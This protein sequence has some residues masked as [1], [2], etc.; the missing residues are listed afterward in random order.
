MLVGSIQRV[1]SRVVVGGASA[2]TLSLQAMAIRP[3]SL[4]A[5]A[6]PTKAG[7]PT[8]A[9]PRMTA[10]ASTVAVA[11]TDAGGINPA[12]AEQGRCGRGFSPDA[13]V[14]GNGDL[15]EERRG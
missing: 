2:P 5:E 6:P 8:T 14:A 3:K 13:V 11:F 15:A 1:L 12:S 4:G 9:V 10:T 7:R